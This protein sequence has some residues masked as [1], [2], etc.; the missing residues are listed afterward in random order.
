MAATSDAP[1]LYSLNDEAYTVKD[2]AED[3]R[4]HTVIDRDGNDIGSVE[5][6]LIDGNEHR[7]RFLQ[8]HEGGFLGMGGRRFLIPVDVITRIGDDKVFI[9]RTSDHV[10][11]GP[12]YEPEV[13][14]EESLRRDAFQEG[15]Y[16]HGL[17]GHY[18][19]TP[20]WAPGYAYPGYPFYV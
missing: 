5:D 12:T 9:D 8:I 16:Y 18:G 19:Y 20:F 3:V 13:V 7:V 1:T 14:A 10:G 11:A 6:L 4:K 17:Y 15:G 2:P